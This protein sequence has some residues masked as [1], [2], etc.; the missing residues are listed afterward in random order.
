MLGVLLPGNREVRVQEFPDPKPGPKEVVVRVKASAIC[1]SDMSLYYG[2]PLVGRKPAGSVIP[3]HEPAGI[4]QT[5]GR[6][7][8]HVVE[9][10]RVAIYLAIGCGRCRYCRGGYLNLCNDWL[11]LGFDVNGGD[12][13]LCVVPE[14][15]CLKM[16][17]KMSFA[18]GAASTD[19]VG[20]LYDAAKR[21]EVAG[22]D[23]VAIFGLGPMG[24][25]GLLVCKALGARVLGV[26]LV[27]DRLRAAKNLG[28][29][30]VI[31]PEEGEPVKAIK[32]LTSGI[33]ADVAIDCSGTPVAESNALDCVRKQGRVAFIGEC[34]AA[35]IKPSDQFIRKRLTVMGCWYFNISLYEDVA[36]LIM[37]KNMPVE[38]IITHR[39]SLQEADKAF[40]LFNDRQT[41]KTIFMP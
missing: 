37:N 11:C 9:G 23:T 16:P 6:D 12:A 27:E 15:N 2:T 8:R 4:V 17:E 34:A 32:D 21:L 13:E 38:K 10:D 5:I 40:K 3:G 22:D 35:Q 26:D 24:L 33:G 14:Y 20:T 1:R 36:E 30:Q 19:A 39:F 31:N 28:V 29:D 18:V 7:V 25:S 41:L